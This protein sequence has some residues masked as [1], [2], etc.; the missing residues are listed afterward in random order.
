MQ[1]RLYLN[2]TFFAAKPGI[3]RANER[4][5][6]SRKLHSPAWV[7]STHPIRTAK[8]VYRR[9]ETTKEKEKPRWA[10]G[11]F[12][13]VRCAVRYFTAASGFVTHMFGEA[14]FPFGSPERKLREIL[15]LQ[16]WGR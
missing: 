15:I 12:K 1:V 2:P 4:A 13:N 14:A 6:R 5:S 11:G 16:P 7:T 3:L 10:V 8:T 9:K